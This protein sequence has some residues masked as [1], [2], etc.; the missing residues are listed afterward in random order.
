MG[1]LA[2]LDK[3]I[4]GEGDFHGVEVFAL[5]VL[6]K[7]HF[8]HLAVGGHTD[9][10]RK[11]GEPCDLRSAQTA[12][13]SNKLV[14]SVGHAA[15]GNGTYDTLLANGLG[16]FLQAVVVKFLAGLERVGLNVADV[17]HADGGGDI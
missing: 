8:H 5:Y 13:S 16:Q 4:V 9:V 17:H 10:G 14:F 11:F 2:L 12:F 7:C 3:G 1:E 15:D 6:H